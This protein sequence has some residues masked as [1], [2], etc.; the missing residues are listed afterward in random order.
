MVDATVADDVISGAAVCGDA[1]SD[2]D[3]DVGDPVTGV[4]VEGAATATEV[5]V[6]SGAKRDR[7][8]VH[9]MPDVTATSAAAATANRRTFGMRRFA[10]AAR[11]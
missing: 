11:S 3:D 6:A 2:A 4:V 8:T 7:A 9:V 1:D 5:D 10:A